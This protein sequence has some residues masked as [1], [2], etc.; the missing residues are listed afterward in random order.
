METSSFKRHYKFP[1][2]EDPG[3]D[4]NFPVNVI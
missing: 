2:G 3:F 1:K 4:N